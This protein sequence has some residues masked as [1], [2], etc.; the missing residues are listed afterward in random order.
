MGPG[1]EPWLFDSAY[2]LFFKLVCFLFLKIIYILKSAQIIS[3]YLK[4]FHKM[5]APTLTGTQIKK[6]NIS[7][8]LR[9]LPVLPSG[10]LLPTS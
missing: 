7:T 6:Q 9:S 10:H 8:L 3:I 5:Y 4:N 2:S 1:F